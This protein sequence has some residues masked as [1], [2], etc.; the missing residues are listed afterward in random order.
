MLQQIAIQEFKRI[1][2]KRFGIELSD[3]EASFRANNL[4][5]FYAIVY[6]NPEQKNDQEN[7]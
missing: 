4:V 2:Q 1:Y 7:S 5:S 3:E 6:K